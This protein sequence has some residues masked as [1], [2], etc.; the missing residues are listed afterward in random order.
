MWDVA[1]PYNGTSS[2]SRLS[3]FGT[4]RTSFNG[5]MAHL[6]DY[7]G[8]GG[9][10]WLNTLCSGTSSRMA[11]SGIYG[12]FSNVPTYSWSVEVVTHEQGHNLGS[13]HTHA[14]VWNGNSTAIDGCGPTA[15]Y[16]EGS[17][18]NAGLPAGGGTDRKSVV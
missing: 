12:S 9:V 5:E 11:Y 2:G 15:G 16:T 10:A 18:P 1:S 3:Q 14:C 13:S 4:T 8:Y 17:C 7:G 6:L